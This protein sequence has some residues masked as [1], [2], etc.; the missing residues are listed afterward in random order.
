MVGLR[1][2]AI[3]TA[4]VKSRFIEIHALFGASPCSIGTDFGASAAFLRHSIRRAVFVTAAPFQLSL[5]AEERGDRSE[6]TAVM[7]AESC[8]LNGVNFRPP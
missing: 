2:A 8:P 3:G 1:D 7:E 4:G 6:R 5:R